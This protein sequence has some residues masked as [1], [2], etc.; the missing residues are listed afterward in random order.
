M[1]LI[2]KFDKRIDFVL[3]VVDGFS[4]YIW[5]ILLKDKKGI[6][7]TN[8][9]Q[10]ILDESSRKVNKIWVDTSSQF[11]KRSMKSWLEKNTI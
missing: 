10:K 11:Y 2:S 5:V 1:Q 9:F 4:K 7:T 6:R 3:C 8:T